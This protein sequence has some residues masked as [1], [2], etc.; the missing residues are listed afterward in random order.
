MIVPG[1]FGKDKQIDEV[2]PP[3]A[4][5]VEAPTEFKRKLY[6]MYLLLLISSTLSTI[7]A[8]LMTMKIKI[9]NAVLIESSCCES[10][11]C[12][13]DTHSKTHFKHPMLMVVFMFIGEAICLP[14]G[15]LTAPEP[16]KPD[17][18]L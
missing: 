7:L 9:P 14:F 4:P 6:L 3:R 12:P 2:K 13:L 10:M 16:V 17:Q 1:D 18:M 5:Q 8:K 11:V 15:Y